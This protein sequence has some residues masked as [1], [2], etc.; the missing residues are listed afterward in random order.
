[1]AKI[2]DFSDFL[3]KNLEMGVRIAVTAQTLHGFCSRTGLYPRLA[4]SKTMT[5]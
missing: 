5:A 4:P 2:K 1:V 3:E